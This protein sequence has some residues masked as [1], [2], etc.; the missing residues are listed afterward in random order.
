[1]RTG[2]DCEAVPGA[3]GMSQQAIQH[4]RA[5]RRHISGVY[6]TREAKNEMCIYYDPQRLVPDTQCRYKY[7]EQRA[8]RWLLMSLRLSDYGQ[9][10]LESAQ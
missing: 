3:A 6:A 7:R 10:H 1:M 2:S 5:L 8:L 4:L 9:S